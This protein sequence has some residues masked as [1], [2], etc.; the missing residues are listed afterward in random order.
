[1]IESFSR[2]D[3][4]LVGRW[5]WTVDRPLLICFILLLILGILLSLAG[6]PSTAGRL[7]LD[8]FYFV[9]RHGLMTFPALAIIFLGSLASPRLLRY[10]CWGVL[11]FSIVM[12]VLTPFM[13]MEIKGARRWVNLGGFSLQATELVKP[14]FGV[15]AAWLFSQSKE[16]PLSGKLLALILYGVLMTLILLQPDFGMAFIISLTWFVQIF[17]GGL[18]LLWIIILSVLGVGGIGLAYLLLPHVTSR[19]DRFLNPA[20]GDQYQITQ[21]LEAFKN[22]GILGQG[23][24]EGVFKRYL[25]DA[26]ADFIFPVAAEEFGFFFCVFVISIYAFIFVRGFMLIRLEKNLFLVLS[27]GGLITQFTLQALVNISSALK[28]IPTKGM[29]LPFLSY[30]GSSLLGT[31]LTVAIVLSMTRKRID[32]SRIY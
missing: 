29:T 15:I 11:G 14:S 8:S 20:V 28:L 6:S 10:I 22:G 17:L 1:M 16:Y 21:S 31:A 26:H 19:I 18:P 9:K 27:L 5:W 30:G 13:G 3:K 25:P 32:D 4:S 24:G 7:H 23:P 2:A 12:L